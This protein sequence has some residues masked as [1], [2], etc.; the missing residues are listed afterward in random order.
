MISIYQIK[1]KFQQLLAPI[2]KCLARTG[3]SPNQ[4]TVGTTLLLTVYGSALFLNPEQ[5]PL[6]F[7]LPVVLLLRMA[8]NAIDGMLAVSTQQ[9]TPFGALLNELCD[10]IADI[11]LYLPFIALSGVSSSTLLAVLFTA[12]LTEFSG[13]LALSVGSQRRHD[14][15]MGKSDR[16]FAFGVL[17]VMVGFG[18]KGAWINGFLVLI[19]ALHLL[20]IFNRVRSA[21]AAQPINQ[22]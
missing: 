18:V 19:L 5:T 20:T 12:F 2:L 8:S 3:V 13:V 21:L 7:G 10:V 9:Q 1:P 6:W 11:A 15:P 17:A 4:I 14:G 16:A 22:S